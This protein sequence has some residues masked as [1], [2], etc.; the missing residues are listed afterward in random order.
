MHTPLQGIAIRQAESLHKGIAYQHWHTVHAWI[1]IRPEEEIYIERAE[2]FDR[3]SPSAATGNQIKLRSSRISLNS[4]EVASALA[5][6]FDLFERHPGRPFSYR[7]TT[8]AAPREEVG[9]PFGAGKMG[10]EVWKTALESQDAQKGITNFLGSLEHLPA[11]VRDY[12][13]DTPSTV[14]W[15]QFLG[16]ISFDLNDSSF[17]ELQEKV[18]AE[19]VERGRCE[20]VGSHVA[21]QFAHLLFS[22]VANRAAHLNSRPLTKSEFEDLWEKNAKDLRISP[23]ARDKIQ[24]GVS[25]PVSFQPLMH[26]LAD[27]ESL[28]TASFPRWDLFRTKF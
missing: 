18:A 14:V 7:L 2:D 11:K 27:S 20:N 16:R 21:R 9:S 24:Y 8:N 22:T 6:A 12:I 10:L 1:N 13:H 4:K 28:L 5:H 19:L 15:S 25:E 3:I 17:P 26:W 23:A